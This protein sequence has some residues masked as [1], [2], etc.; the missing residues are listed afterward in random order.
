MAFPPLDGTREMADFVRESFRWHWRSATRLPHPLPDDYQDLF[1]HLTLSDV[2][3]ATL[4]FELPEMIQ[5]TFYAMLLNNAVEPGIVSIFLVVNLKLTLKGL[6]W[7]S[8]EAWL[9]CT[10]H[11]LQEGQLQQ[12][13][14]PFGAG[15]S[16]D[17]QEERSG[18]TGPSPLSSDEE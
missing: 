11:D 8:F 6:R 2:E 3:R 9:S 7:T 5:V 10:S 18:S 15:G 16:M 14:L 13:T 1:P 17:G 4:D 12:R